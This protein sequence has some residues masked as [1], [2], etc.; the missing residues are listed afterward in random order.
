MPSAQVPTPEPASDQEVLLYIPT[1]GIFYMPKPCDLGPR[2]TELTRRRSIGGSGT[3][4]PGTRGQRRRPL[5]RYGMTRGPDLVLRSAPGFGCH[6]PPAHLTVQYLSSIHT[7]SA[8]ERPDGTD[9]RRQGLR[10]GDGLTP[11]RSAVLGVMLDWPSV[12]LGG[13]APKALQY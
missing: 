4:W 7:N 12:A 11:G 10:H 9:A 3:T 1:Y 8:L 5:V 2:P 6:F 13:T